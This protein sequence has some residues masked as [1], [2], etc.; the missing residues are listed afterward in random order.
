MDNKGANSQDQIH[1]FPFFIYFFI[2]AK[3]SLVK[4]LEEIFC[5]SQVT[6]LFANEVSVLQ[7]DWK[8]C[9]SLHIKNFA[10]YCQWMKWILSIIKSISYDTNIN[11][12]YIFFTR[13][14]GKIKGLRLSIN[15]RVLQRKCAKVNCVLKILKTLLNRRGMYT[16]IIVEKV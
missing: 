11:V 12:F 13:L 15:L 8:T 2:A 16:C 6:F 14:Q 5:F 1:N 9:G 7:E 4:I 10:W 3:N